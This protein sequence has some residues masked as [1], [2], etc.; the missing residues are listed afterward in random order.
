MPMSTPNPPSSPEQEVGPEPLPEPTPN[1]AIDQSV[2][3]AQ[4]TKKPTNEPTNEPTK[5]PMN[6]RPNHSVVEAERIRSLRNMKLLATALLL[7]VTIGFVVARIFE[8]QNGWL[9]YVRAGCEAAMIGALADWFAVTALFRHPLGIPIPHTAIVA[10]RKNEIG[11]GLGEFVETNFLTPEVLGPKIAAIEPTQRLARW[12]VM[13]Q[14]THTTSERI[15]QGLI[16]VLDSIDDTEVT[17]FLEGRLS[18]LVTKF[19][20]AATLARVLRNAGANRRREQIVDGVLKRAHDALLDNRDNIAHQFISESPWWVPN[21]VDQRMFDRLFTGI[22]T[23]LGAM[24]A[25]HN[26]ELRMALDRRIDRYIIELETNPAL[27]AKFDEG[28]REA[29]RHPSIRA[30]IEGWW[31]DTKVQLAGE[32]A[33]PESKIRERISRS[34]EDQAKAILADQ[35][36]AQR[37]NDAI[38]R[39]V[40]SAVT[41]YG[42]ELSGL[43]AATVERWD[44]KETVTRIEQQIGR[45]LQFI[46]I[47]GTIVGG[48]VG[49]ILFTLGKLL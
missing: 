41:S 18:S 17:A 10:E 49:V 44:T 38:Q 13:P 1:L 32:L 7:L 48:I 37:Y 35:P 20:P 11:K 24:R 2:G 43:I 39:F 23:T 4:H 34:V 5:K 8:E 6:E 45:D 30:A 33:H 12:L 46:R 42:H 47:N 31:A 15:A 29:L 14:N 26:H 21:S 28:T 36:R 27:A 22:T 16:K 9:G 40:V 3:D 25:D 19:P